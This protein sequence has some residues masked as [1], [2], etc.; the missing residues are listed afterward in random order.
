MVV[1]LV[2]LVM[3]LPMQLM[4]LVTFLMTQEMQLMVPLAM[5][6]VV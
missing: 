5:W 3:C 2:L 1:F 4:A 6:P